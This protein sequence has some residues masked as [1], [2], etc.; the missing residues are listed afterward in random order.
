MHQ[1]TAFKAWFLVHPY[2][3]INWKA[4]LGLGFSL[5]V[6]VPWLRSRAMTWATGSAWPWPQQAR[7]MQSSSVHA[8]PGSAHLIMQAVIHMCICGF[9]WLHSAVHAEVCM[10]ANLQVI[11][12]WIS[13]VSSKK[14]GAVRHSFISLF[15]HLICLASSLMILK[16]NRRGATFILIFYIIILFGMQAA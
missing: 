15:Y 12:L 8:Y 7:S 16:K 3:R 2:I 10:Y 11:C 13:K 1:N 6:L 5:S 14:I 4:S 9:L